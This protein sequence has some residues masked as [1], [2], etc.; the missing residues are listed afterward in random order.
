MLSADRLK[1]I[2][3]VASEYAA[4]FGDD[5]KFKSLREA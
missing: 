4:L 3:Q 1:A 2:S 5:P